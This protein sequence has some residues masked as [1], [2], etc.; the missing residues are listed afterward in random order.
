MK[1]LQLFEDYYYEK[2]IYSVGDWVETKTGLIMIITDI[3]TVVKR[4]DRAENVYQYEGV[5]YNNVDNFCYYT[6]DYI[7]R[8]L[9][10]EEVELYK[11]AQKYNV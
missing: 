8:K 1:H 7:I 5:L 10:E 6:E 2:P 9:T 3:D 11:N 4:G